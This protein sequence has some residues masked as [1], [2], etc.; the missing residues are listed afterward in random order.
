[1]SGDA[2]ERWQIFEEAST[3]DA[4]I[5]GLER[6]S[7]RRRHVVQRNT[8]VEERVFSREFGG[9]E[10]VAMADYR[11]TL[12]E[13]ARYLTDGTYGSFVA[14][15]AMPDCVRVRLFRR[16]LNPATDDVEVEIATEKEF[17][18]EQIADSAAFAEEL[19]GQANQ[20]NDAL[21]Q[22][23]HDAEARAASERAGA[24]EKAREAAEL[25]AILRDAG[26]DAPN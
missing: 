1:M 14:M 24:R 19:R 25:A 5:I 2:A 16:L 20:E 7:E 26:K 10:I 9:R 22:G 6:I 18:S 11:G 12:E 3:G 21:W 8:H 15:D 17:P 13:L 23:M 4:L